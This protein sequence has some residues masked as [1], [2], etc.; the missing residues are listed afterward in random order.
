[1][2]RGCPDE[3]SKRNERP[4]ERGI[5]QVC[6]S[7]ITDRTATDNRPSVA[8]GSYWRRYRHKDVIHINTLEVIALVCD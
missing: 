7:V 8:L 3:A 4:Q 2:T 6:D 5:K 1:M